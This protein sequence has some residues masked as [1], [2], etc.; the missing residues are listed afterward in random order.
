MRLRLVR[1]K[2]GK[3]EHHTHFVGAEGE[4]T[5][6]IDKPELRFHDGVTPGGHAIP[7]PDEV[8]ARIMTIYY[9]QVKE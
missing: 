5:L 7:I 8:Y 2:R 9:P 1:L 6:V 4:F 3:L